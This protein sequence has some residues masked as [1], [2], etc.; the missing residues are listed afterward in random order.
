[1]FAPLLTTKH[2]YPQGRPNLIPSLR[3]FRQNIRD[4]FCQ[5]LARK[6]LENTTTEDPLENQNADHICKSAPVLTRTSRRAFF[7]SLVSPVS[8]TEM[9]LQDKRQIELC[10]SNDIGA[11]HLSAAGDVVRPSI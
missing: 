10:E 2:Y 11:P 8:Y 9:L 4:L 1:M 3:L 7:V 5:F 6:M